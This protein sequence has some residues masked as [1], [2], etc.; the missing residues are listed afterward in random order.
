M[1]QFIAFAT[2][3]A[4]LQS[5]MSFPNYVTTFLVLGNKDP[6]FSGNIK[7]SVLR[8]KFERFYTGLTLPVPWLQVCMP[9]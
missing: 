8:R 4:S 1:V 9:G 3:L 7:L 2:K 5:A 6:L